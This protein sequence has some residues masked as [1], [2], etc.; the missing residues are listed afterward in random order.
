[1]D[2]FG[3]ASVTPPTFEFDTGRRDDGFIGREKLR[4]VGVNHAASDLADPNLV[5]AGSLVNHLKRR[6]RT[7]VASY[8]IL[9]YPGVMPISSPVSDTPPIRLD[10]SADSFGNAFRDACSGI[11]GSVL[12]DPITHP[13]DCVFLSVTP[14]LVRFESTDRVKVRSAHVADKRLGCFSLSIIDQAVDNLNLTVIEVD[15]DAEHPRFLVGIHALPSCASCLLWT[16]RRS[17]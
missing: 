10:V 2:G 11:S 4:V 9:G 16:V 7:T 6:V 5:R 17:V 14:L 3:D 13:A 1:M 12:R 8:P 15:T